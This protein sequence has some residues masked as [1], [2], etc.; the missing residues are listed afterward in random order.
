M[1]S[2]I[3]NILLFTSILYRNRDIIA[4]AKLVLLC[5]LDNINL[6][7]LKYHVKVNLINLSQR[8]RIIEHYI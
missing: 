2:F 5:V 6:K 3:Y 7:R 4:L 1:L 8:I